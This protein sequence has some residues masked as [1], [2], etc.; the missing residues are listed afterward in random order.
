MQSNTQQFGVDP[1]GEF[2]PPSPS[3]PRASWT[4]LTLAA[5]FA[6]VMIALASGV[7]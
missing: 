3:I 6:V 5:V 1:G 2:A 4:W 7:R